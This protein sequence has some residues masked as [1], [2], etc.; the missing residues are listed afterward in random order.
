M[1]HASMNWGR[2]TNSLCGDRCPDDAARSAGETSVNYWRVQ[3]E[4]TAGKRVVETGIDHS[5]QIPNKSL[6]L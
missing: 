4:K 3:E 2:L 6:T 1:G 5:L